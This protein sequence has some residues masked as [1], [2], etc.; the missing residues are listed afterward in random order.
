MQEKKENAER[1]FGESSDVLL[2]GLKKT[3]AW[4]KAVG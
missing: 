3:I 1:K 4:G 2:L